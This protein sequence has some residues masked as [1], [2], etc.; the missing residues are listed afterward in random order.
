MIRSRFSVLLAAGLSSSCFAV[1]DLDRFEPAQAV[2]PANFNNLKVTVRG[3]TSHVAERVEFNVI[4]SQ[5]FVQS[6]TLIQPLGGP[7]ATFSFVGAVPKQNGPFRLDFY[8][9][10]DNS[11]GYTFPRPDAF[12]DHSW[13]IELTDAILDKNTNTYVIE[14]LH[15]QSFVDLPPPIELGKRLLVHLKAMQPF[16]GKR[17]EVRV[18]DAATQRGVALSR[19]PQ[20]GEPDKDLEVSGMLE[21]G[22]GYR[23]EVYTDDG[24]GGG[25]V[26]FRFDQTADPN[27][28][29]VTFDGAN[30]GPPVTD[31]RAP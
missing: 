8:A 24:N 14:F 16:L 31:A 9:D 3:M 20:L 11:G 15:N 26:A 6:R 12:L 4:D 10:H 5:N 1:T 7:D 23:V 18:S 13:R 28:L 25:I 29:E 30:P 22:V 27:G 17:V 19:V 2:A 21:T